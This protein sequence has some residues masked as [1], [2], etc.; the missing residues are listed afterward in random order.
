MENFIAPDDDVIR[1][2]VLVRIRNVDTNA[3]E[4]VF[5]MLDTCA[6]KD[7]ISENV[8]KRLNLPNVTKTMTVQT[9]DT[10]MTQKRRL[11][12]LQLESIHSPYKIDIEQALVAKVWC[13][14]NDIPPHKRNLSAFTHLDDVKFDEADVEAYLAD[15][16]SYAEPDEGTKVEPDS[17]FEK[18]SLSIT[19]S[20]SLEEAFSDARRRTLLVAYFPR[21]ATEHDLVQAIGKVGTIRAHIER[22][23]DGASKCFGMVEFIDKNSAHAAYNACRRSEVRLDD[24][25]GHTW[26]LRANVAIGDWLVPVPNV[27]QDC[28]WAL[29]RRLYPDGET[30]H[31]S[32]ELEG[33]V[34]TWMLDW[35]SPFEVVCPLSSALADHNL[36]QAAEARSHALVQ[37]DIRA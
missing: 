25:F 19:Q 4:L 24:L 1:P 29:A 6:D 36:E 23:E 35:P 5:A 17:I 7:V 14:E 30:L 11:A 26:H 32:D 21:A 12:N 2:I 9:V 8:V 18:Q 3:S 33:W 16:P 13:S 27:E 22:E 31:P 28:G 10:K 37:D 15:I 34:L 20:E